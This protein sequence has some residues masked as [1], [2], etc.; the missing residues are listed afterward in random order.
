MTAVISNSQTELISFCSSKKPPRMS[1]YWTFMSLSLHLNDCSCFC[2]MKHK[3][4]I[5]SSR[6]CRTRRRK[7]WKQWKN[8]KLRNRQNSGREKNS[9]N[10]S[11]RKNK[12]ERK[13]LKKDQMNQMMNNQNKRKISNNLLWSRVKSQLRRLKIPP[14]RDKIQIL[15]S[16]RAQKTI[17]WS[18]RWWKTFN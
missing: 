16:Q 10:R 15:K 14:R 8:E 9:L 6:N 13:N 17:R 2:S 7:D 1:D 5:R 12:K 18:R 11:K 3:I 4:M